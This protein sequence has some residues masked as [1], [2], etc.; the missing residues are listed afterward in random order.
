VNA[1][2]KVMFARRGGIQ[3]IGYSVPQRGAQLPRVPARDLLRDNMRIERAA[4]MATLPLSHSARAIAHGFHDPDINAEKIPQSKLPPQ[5]E[6]IKESLERWTVPRERILGTVKRV[7]IAPLHADGAEIPAE[8][9][10]Q[11]MGMARQELAPLGWEITEWP[12]AREVL[13]ANMRDARPFDPFTG[14]LDETRRSEARK[15]ALRSLGA[16]QVDAIL[17]LSI[18]RTTAIQRH[19]VAEWDD[20]EQRVMLTGAILKQPTVQAIESTGIRSMPASSLLATLTDAS[21]APWFA[22]RGGLQLMQSLDVTPL[23]ASAPIIREND[24]HPNTLFGYD[25]NQAKAVH[26]ALRHLTLSPEALAAE[27][28]AHEADKQRRGSRYLTLKE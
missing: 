16:G 23:I 28:A 19:G 13:L 14:E 7:A 5:P 24:F 6:Q 8:H 21:D 4:R 22:S 9:A 3:L 12:N 25:K 11:L 26:A 17:W 18:V 10:S 20:V 1:A 15:S 2:G 27:I